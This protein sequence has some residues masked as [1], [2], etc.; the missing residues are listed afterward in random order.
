[1][2]KFSA[3]QNKSGPFV[4]FTEEKIVR[5][6]IRVGVSFVRL[7]EEGARRLGGDMS[8]FHTAYPSYLIF[9]APGA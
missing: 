4:K 3:S 7:E 5:I 2:N 9:Y 6:R 8:L 1:M